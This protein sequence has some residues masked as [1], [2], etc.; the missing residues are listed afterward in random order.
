[1]SSNSVEAI[2]VDHLSLMLGKIPSPFFSMFTIVGY[3]YTMQDHATF[4]I[5]L[6]DGNQ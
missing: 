3:Y 1:M 2:L 6:D 5:F 4:K